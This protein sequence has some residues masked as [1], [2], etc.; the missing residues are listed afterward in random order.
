MQRVYSLSDL[1]C[2]RESWNNNSLPPKSD[3]RRLWVFITIWE[4]ARGLA[5][6]CAVQQEINHSFHYFSKKC[7]KFLILQ[8]KH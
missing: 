7:Q 5:L 4:R 8:L 3:A 1:R 2:K 6:Y